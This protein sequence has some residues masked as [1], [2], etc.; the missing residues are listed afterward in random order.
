MSAA[1][2]RQ[3]PGASGVPAGFV[4]RGPCPLCKGDVFDAHM[5]FPDI[6]VRRCAACG[7]IHPAVVMSP[8]TM[9]AYYREVFHSP[10]HRQG[11]KLNSFVNEAA[12]A[13]LIDLRRVKSFL[14]VGTGYGFLLQRL[15]RRGIACTGTEPS[16]NEA[17][18]ARESLG[19]NVVANLVQDAGLQEA[20]FD[21]VA[22]FEVIEHVPD[23]IPFIAT[24]ARYAK[25]G[26]LVVI[27]TDNFEN[28]TVRALGPEFPKWIPHSHVSDFAPATLERAI[29]AADGTSAPP[30]RAGLRV[31]SRLSYTAW[32]MAA[33]RAVMRLRGTQPR[34]PGACFSFERERAREMNRAYRFWPL[35]LAV[36]RAWFALAHRRDLAGSMMFVAARKGG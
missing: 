7:F 15:G 33:R 18:Y 13:R 25:P 5:P 32:E 19:L 10:W 21:C 27:N 24:L 20:S 9:A 28:A 11:Q 26:G 23:P 14:D 35:R 36:A 30:G 3:M 16:V 6:P 17:R 34:E 31:E 29:H 22:C 8:E 4:A 12:L 2:S 1:G